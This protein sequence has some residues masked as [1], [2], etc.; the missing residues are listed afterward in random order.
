MNARAMRVVTTLLAVAAASAT[1]MLSDRP[2]SSSATTPITVASIAGS[3]PA[4]PLLS[5]TTSAPEAPPDLVSWYDSVRDDVN[6]K[7]R[8]RAIEAWDREAPRDA[9]TDLLTHALVD[10]DPAVRERAQAL[11]D[12]RMAR[13]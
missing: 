10:P 11:F 7:S 5:P 3:R 4:A 6:P 13:R 9:G 12:R 8:L 1:A 2:R